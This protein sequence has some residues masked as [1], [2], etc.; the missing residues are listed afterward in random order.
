MS[1]D[2]ILLSYSKSIFGKFKNYIKSCLKKLLWPFSNK[3]HIRTNRFGHIRT[4]RFGHFLTNPIVRFQKVSPLKEI[5]F[6]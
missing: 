5:I 3:F 2:F 1:Q 6:W 4:N